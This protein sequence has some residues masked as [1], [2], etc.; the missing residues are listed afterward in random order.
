MKTLKQLLRQPLKTLL[1]VVLMTLAIA[2]LCVCV[3][4]ALAARNT[5]EILDERFSTVAFFS[6]LEEF[7]DKNQYIVEEEALQWLE[8]MALEHPEIVKAVAP[9]GIL[10]AYI[11]ELS[12]YNTLSKDVATQETMSEWIS[13]MFSVGISGVNYYDSAMLVITLDE[14][15][16][17]TDPGNQ[18]L[19]QPVPEDFE[20]IDEYLAYLQTWNDLQKQKLMRDALRRTFAEG[21]TVELSG[22]ITQVVSLPDGM[23][24]PVGMHAKLTLTLP[25]REDIEALDLQVG[26]QYI[27]YGL[28]YFDDYHYLVEYMKST[29]MKHVSWEP[30]DPALLREPTEEEIRRYKQNKNINV[31]M[32]YNNAPLERWQYDLFN[33]ISMSVCMPSNLLKYERV[34]GEDGS[35]SLVPQTE[36]SYTDPSGVQHTLT[37]EEFNRRY[38]IPTITRLEGSVEEF[39]ASQQGLLWKTAKEQSQV[40]NHAFAV[41]GVNDLHELPTFSLEDSKVAEGREFTAEEV[42]NGAK[43]CIIHEWVAQNS[44]LQIG[45]TIT[46]GLYTTDYGLP[47][48]KTVVEDKG[49]LRPSASYYFSTTPIL[50]TAEYTIVGFW[51]GD[52]WPDANKNYYGFSANTVFVPATS[53]QTPME[54]RNT[55]PFVSVLLENGTISQFHD[56]V[57]RSGYAGRFMYLDQGYEEIAVNFHNY[58]ALGQQIMM[59]GVALYAMLLLLFLV[60]YPTTQKKTVYTMESLGCSYFR[61]F[62]H[63]LLSSMTVMTLA[64]ALGA[65]IGVALWDSVVAALQSTT[66]SSVALQ[67][68][69]NVLLM[70]AGAQLAL[71]LLLNILVSLVIAMPRGISA[72]R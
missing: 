38:A 5:K 53:V 13:S 48:Q 11:P 37:M 54:Q 55:I 31:Y 64:T 28:D 41:L 22:T 8:K 32:I 15:G 2:V 72:R 65:G 6:L 66:E 27:V 23:R 71:A 61:R 45:D 29:K 3:C 9:N 26:Q 68:D 18:E 43:V 62:G 58:E 36:V 40:N 25:S 57:R 44:G 46:L 20:T 10:S 17:M 52:V 33:S 49:L 14:I 34:V 63:V 47:Y 35:V 67:L 70:V 12:P 56:L 42:A 69:P 7:R 59:V 51:E 19:N 21:Y 60:L 1:G 39:L 30:F 50:E 4:Q 24:D 16:V